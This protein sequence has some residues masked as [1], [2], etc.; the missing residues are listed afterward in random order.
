VDDA[1]TLGRML[2]QLHDHLRPFDGELGGLRELRA[3]I[4]RLLRRLRPTNAEQRDAHASLGERLSMLNAT[5]FESRL[6]TQALHGDVSLRNLL[7]TPRRLLWNDF[8]DTFRGP[9]HW[10]VASAVGSLRIH[11][12]D[13]R[14]VSEMLDAYGWVDEQELAPFLAAQD[15]Y[16]EIWRLYDRQR[17]HD[18]R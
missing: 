2:R 15:I 6:P 9:V 16:D 8:E 18:C 1:R 3:D 14:S 12:T 10:D 5:V 7:R 17:Q 13:A 11:G 4:E